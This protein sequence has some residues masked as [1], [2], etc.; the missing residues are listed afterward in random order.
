[1]PNGGY[2]ST[3]RLKRIYRH[4]YVDSRFMGLEFFGAR[5]IVSC[6]RGGAHPDIYFSSQVTG[7]TLFHWTKKPLD[8]VCGQSNRLVLFKNPV[9]SAM[10]NNAYIYH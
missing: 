10:L 5:Q 6:K 4:Y 9:Y 1:M 7:W 3:W 8:E 2:Y